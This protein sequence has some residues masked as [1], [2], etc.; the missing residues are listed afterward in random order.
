MFVGAND[1]L[2]DATD[3][4]W[5]YSN[6]PTV[7]YYEEIPGGHASFIVGKNYT[8]FDTVLNLMSKY[9]PI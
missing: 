5:A 9:N 2:A 8:F 3:A 7:T 1:D 4:K 6:I